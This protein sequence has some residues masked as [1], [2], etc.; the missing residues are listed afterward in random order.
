LKKFFVVGCQRSGTTM[1]QQALNRHPRIVI[2]PETAF[3][4]HFLGHT[5]RGQ[6]QHLK[7]INADLKIDLPPPQRRVSHPAEAAAFFNQLAELYIESI[8]RA[9]VDL[10]GEKTPH[11]VLRIN[12][13]TRVFPDAKIILIFRDG[14]D[15]ALSLTKVPWFNS[16][17]DVTFGYWL[18]CYRCQ[19]R[20]MQTRAGDLHCVKYEDLV[21]QPEDELRRIA[22]F[23]GIDYDPRMAEGHGSLDGVPKWELGWKHRAKEKITTARIAH[24]RGELSPDQLKNLEC[25]GRRQLME[26]GYEVAVDPTER[27]PLSFFPRLY[28]KVL[29]WRAGN[30]CRVL[31]KDLLGR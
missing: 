5:R 18:K 13:I 4:T 21:A 17:V 22:E 30:A 29:T 20:A 16:N 11:H 19:K 15:V 8:G 3:F 6:I 25:W 14:R 31:M 28:W 7:R 10:F 24:A 26:L 27:L 12:R 1:L 23:L 2:P 9:D